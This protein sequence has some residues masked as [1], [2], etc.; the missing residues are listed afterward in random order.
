M[1]G[2]EEVREAAKR[3]RFLLPLVDA[4]AVEAMLAWE[5]KHSSGFGQFTKTDG[6][7]RVLVRNDVAQPAHL[8][9]Q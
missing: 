7:I 4:W 6:T 5:L 8:A 1:V 2:R 9:M 3:A